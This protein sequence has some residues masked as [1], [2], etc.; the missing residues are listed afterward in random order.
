MVDW[1]LITVPDDR[2]L[3]FIVVSG[4]VVSLGV[5]VSMSS[6][7]RVA[8]SFGFPDFSLNVMYDEHISVIKVDMWS[9]FQVPVKGR[10]ERRMLNIVIFLM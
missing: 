7:F 2:L 3:V 5:V 1:S 8:T 6:E 9:S 4:L 10:G